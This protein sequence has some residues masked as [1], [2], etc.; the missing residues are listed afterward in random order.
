MFPQWARAYS[1]MMTQ[2]KGSIRNPIRAAA[3]DSKTLDIIIGDTITINGKVV[4][5][6]LN[7]LRKFLKREVS[8]YS[9]I[10]ITKNGTVYRTEMIL[11]NQ[12]QEQNFL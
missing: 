3:G 7:K 4:D 11:V 10:T 5:I 2:A 1:F 8:K 6:A 9:K 12:N